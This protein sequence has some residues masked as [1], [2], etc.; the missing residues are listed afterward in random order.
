MAETDLDGMVRDN[1]RILTQVELYASEA[2]ALEGVTA[3]QGYVLLRVL[4]HGG[5]GISL[6]DIHRELGYSMAH[7]S[8]T[9]KGLRKKDYVRIEHCDGDD[10]RKLI[11]AT[12][13]GENLRE[14]LEEAARLVQ[15][16][17]YGCFSQTE[18]EELD[19]L[20]QKMLRNLSSLSQNRQQEVVTREDCTA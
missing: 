12:S 4:R 2:M 19:R 11:Y 13:R 9:V 17:L 20:Q 7:L 3:A 10:R 1:R 16:R 18:L 8:A 6:T 14:A 5:Q 15:Q